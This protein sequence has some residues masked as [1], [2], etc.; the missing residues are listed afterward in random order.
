MVLMV[1]STKMEENVKMVALR[2]WKQP[3]GQLILNQEDDEALRV[4][5]T[6]TIIIERWFV[7]L[8]VCFSFSQK[9]RIQS[10]SNF[11]YRLYATRRMRAN[12]VSHTFQDFSTLLA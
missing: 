6:I 1:G 4:A 9:L 2:A 11:T 3:S 10:S 8:F 7:C 12:V 5:L